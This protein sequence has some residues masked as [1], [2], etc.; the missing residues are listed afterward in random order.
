MSRREDYFYTLLNIQTAGHD[1]SDF[2]VTMIDPYLN[3]AN[4]YAQEVMEM[5][6]DR[7]PIKNVHKYVENNRLIGYEPLRTITSNMI[8][9]L[10]KTP[11]NKYLASD[12]E[13]N[14]RVVTSDNI[15]NDIKTYGNI[16]KCGGKT[17]ITSVDGPIPNI[18]TEAYKLYQAH[19]FN[20]KAA[21]I[22]VAQLN[23]EINEHVGLSVTGIKEGCSDIEKV[24]IPDIVDY[25][26]TSVFRCTNIRYLKIG[27]GVKQIGNQAFYGC[28]KLEQVILGENIEL[29]S[30]R[31][32]AGCKSLR[33]VKFNRRLIEIG[34]QAFYNTHIEEVNI[35]G[36]LKFMGEQ[37]FASCIRL[38]EVKIH[39]TM[40]EKLETKVFDVGFGGMSAIT[41]LELPDTLREMDISHFPDLRQVKNLYI[42]N[43]LQYV[44]DGNSREEV[45]AKNQLNK[46]IDSGEL[47]RM[48][49]QGIHKKLIEIYNLQ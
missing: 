5:I 14:L 37:A 25:I 7:V 20:T 26:N 30:Y 4:F 43:T 19:L 32:F 42:P 36:E 10:Y 41:T 2:I 9:V 11:D 40:V 17:G 45:R 6:L 27:S 18:T 13:G 38:T 29:I 23:F 3:I 49:P 12:I 8:V 44:S 28:T 16:K 33:N 35:Q 22:G 21:L 47:K 46:M 31:A 15:K 39:N 34:H 48:T 1:R 24:I